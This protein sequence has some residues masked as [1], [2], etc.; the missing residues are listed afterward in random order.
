[1]NKSAGVFTGLFVAVFMLAGVSANQAL[2]QEKAKS[3]PPKFERKV[4]L[5][6]DKVLVL[7]ARWKPGA[8]SMSG[9]LPVRVIRALKAGTLQRNYPDGKKGL[10]TQFK[11]GEVKF[12]EAEKE[13]FAL[14]NIGK[15]ELVLYVVYLK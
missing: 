15:S 6:N 9:T 1:M 12:F 3:A 14:K 13:P 5:E 2:A 7:E 4:L 11:T 8:E 10:I